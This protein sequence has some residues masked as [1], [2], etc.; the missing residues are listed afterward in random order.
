MNITRFASSTMLC[1]FLTMAAGASG[2]DIVYHGSLCNPLPG[3]VSKIDYNQFGAFN[4]GTGGGPFGTVNCGGSTPIETIINRVS[5]IV[6]DRSTPSNVQ[7]TVRL[8]DI[9]GNVLWSASD[10]TSGNSVAMDNM[11]FSPG[12]GG[13]AVYTRCDI[14]NVTSSGNSIVS[15]YRIITP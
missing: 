11:E 7:C 5:I 1:A 13:Y 8:T 14:P 6:Y 4:N 15:S 9:F 3:D 2:A 10:V 12:V